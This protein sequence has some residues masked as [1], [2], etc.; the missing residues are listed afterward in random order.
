MGEAPGLV[1]L[2]VLPVLRKV[3]IKCDFGNKD[4]ESRMVLTTRALLRAPG[5]RLLN[6]KC[7][8]KIASQILAKLVAKMPPSEGQN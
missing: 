5:S 1:Y 2:V 4:L 6:Q 3:S 7:R 8:A